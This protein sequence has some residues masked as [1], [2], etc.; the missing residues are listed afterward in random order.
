MCP[1]P[2][3]AMIRSKNTTYDF[4]KHLVSTAI[5]KGVRPTAREFHCSRNTVRKWMRRYLEQG[6][7]GLESRSRAPRKIPHKTPPAWEAEVV[8][9][10]ERTPGFGAERLKREFGLK[11]GISAIKRIIREHGL[12]RRRKKKHRVKRDLRAVKARYKPLRHLQMDVKYLNDIPR[13]HPYYRTPGYPKFQYT[14]RCEKTG[15]TFLTFADEI[16]VTYAELTIRRC[17]KHLERFGIDPSEIQVRTDRGS[18]FDGQV[19]ARKP[20]GFTHTVEQVFGGHHHLNHPGHPNANADVESFHAHEETEF[21][22][23]EDYRNPLDFWEKI[24]TYQTYWNLGRPNGYKG[25][26][27]PL[28][29]LLE[30]DSHLDPR[31]LLLD[32]IPLEAL[33]AKQTSAKVGHD[34]PVLTG[35]A[36]SV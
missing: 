8:R 15:A 24:W 18:E 36:A 5:E 19:V 23:I 21:F 2:Y 11:P 1:C 25:W 17:L 3:Y 33:L 34:V 32:P 9:Q 6:A 20:E 27:T 12:A 30:A 26:K 13:Y 22:D 28:E 7:D 35:A 4:R 10:R 14:L 31:V 29:I 16:A